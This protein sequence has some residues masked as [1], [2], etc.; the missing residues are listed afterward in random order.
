MNLGRLE[1][2]CEVV[3]RGG[4]TA[5]AEH[6]FLTQSAVSQYVKGL[7]GQ[8]GSELLVREGRRIYPTEAGDVIYQAAKEIARVWDEARVTVQELQGA[9]AGSSRVGAS[10]PADYFLP[11]L[12]ARF[13][14]QHPKAH[15][16]VN[17]GRPERVVDQVLRG[18]LDFGFVAATTLPAELSAEPVRN[19]EMIVVAPSDHPLAG[20]LSVE[21]SELLSQPFVCAPAGS[22]MR[23]IVDNQLSALGLDARSIALELDSSEAAKLAV[24][25]GAGLAILFRSSVERELASGA[26]KQLHVG[27][28]SMSHGV[29][30]ISRPKRHF[31]PVM[32]QLMD[33]LKAQTAA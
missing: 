5:A 8:V 29:E 7:E 13:S 26:L 21:R 23:A 1:I 3:D 4:F 24:L 17:V 19:E 25:N 31:S 20:R 27:G 10:N 9:E 15:I 14:R 30:L 11:P 33:Y 28:L 22:Q 2:F 18:E 6:L 12:I 16:V 32:R